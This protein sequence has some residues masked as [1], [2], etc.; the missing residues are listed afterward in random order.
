M[1]K[2]LSA[3]SVEQ[4]ASV[5]HEANR[6]YCRTVGDFSQPA[7]AEAPDWQKKSAM[8]GVQF[9]LDN[10]NATPEG[11]HENWLKEK[12]ADGWS[13]GDVKDPD[14]KKHPCCVPYGGL[15][16][17]QRAKDYIFRNIV[18]AFIAANGG[19]Q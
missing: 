5:A 10:P 12:L 4:M 2:Y 8:N 7:W 13:F 17:E 6:Q 14:N 16:L 1:T 19:V 18:H 11:S 15:P 3:F 9:H